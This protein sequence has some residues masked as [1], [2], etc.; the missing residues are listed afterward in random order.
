[1]VNIHYSYKRKVAQIKVDNDEEYIMLDK[2]VRIS[3]IITELY[4]SGIYY[5]RFSISI[6]GGDKTSIQT[7][8]Y[9]SDKNYEDKIEELK[10]TRNSLL[11]HWLQY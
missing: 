1:M 10:E 11:N 2:I 4:P 6:K 8:Y 9:K 5:S 7:S 3:D